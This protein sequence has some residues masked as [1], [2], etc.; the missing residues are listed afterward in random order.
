MM[1]IV[2]AVKRP[3]EL[4]MKKPVSPIP[5]KGKEKPRNKKD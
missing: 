3:T 2:N 1:R 4:L 5:K